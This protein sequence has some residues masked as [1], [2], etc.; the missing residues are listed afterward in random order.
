FVLARRDLPAGGLPPR[1]WL[2]AA[3]F[4]GLSALAGLL[5]QP[6]WSLLLAWAGGLAAFAAFAWFSLLHDEDREWIRARPV[7]QRWS[8]R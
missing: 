3:G 4:C 8:R 1:W 2:R 5:A 6:G 7:L